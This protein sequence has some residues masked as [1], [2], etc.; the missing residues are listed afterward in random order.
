MIRRPPR[1][2]L[3][4]YPT[5]FRSDDRNLG[6]WKLRAKPAAYFESAHVR[7]IQIKKDQVGGTVE[8]Q[9]QG[10]FARCRHP[11]TK[12]F[13]LEVIPN[14][15]GNVLVILD[16]Q[17]VADS[18]LVDSY[19]HAECLKLIA[20]AVNVQFNLLSL[21]CLPLYNTARH[22]S[23]RFLHRYSRP[24]PLSASRSYQLVPTMPFCEGTEPVTVAA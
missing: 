12:S 1:S 9:L 14:R 17:D 18:G 2:T 23:L 5:L 16:Y 10:V 13:T 4:P 21:T 22:S 7:Q 15:V 6:S 3:F 24:S 20:R 19:G 11:Y 8:D